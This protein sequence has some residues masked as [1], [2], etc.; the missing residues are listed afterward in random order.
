[1]GSTDLK[2]TL[3]SPRNML[4][5]TFY[6]D[7]ITHLHPNWVNYYSQYSNVSELSDT[8]NWSFVTFEPNLKS[9]QLF[10]L[11]IVV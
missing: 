3:F 10:S 5:N 4:S 6:I 8:E 9:Q 1:M 2:Y 11:F 7:Q